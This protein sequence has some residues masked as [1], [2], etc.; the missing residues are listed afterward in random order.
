M[1]NY[2][3]IYPGY[4]TALAAIENEAVIFDKKYTC[5]FLYQ[6]FLLVFR[7]FLKNPKIFTMKD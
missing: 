5:V 7:T 3:S 6:I 1:L 4:R 2:L